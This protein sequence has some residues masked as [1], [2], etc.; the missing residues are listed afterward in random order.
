M[1][2]TSFKCFEF[3][4]LVLSRVCYSHMYQAHDTITR[5]IYV[6]NVKVSTP[7]TTDVGYSTGALSV[8]E[9]VVAN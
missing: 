6:S 9:T 1:H 8:E 3:L 5:I 4:N 2:T 7:Q